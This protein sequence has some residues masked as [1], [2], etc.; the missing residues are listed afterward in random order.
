MAGLSTASNGTDN[1]PN[2]WKGAG[3][4]EFDLRSDTMTKP[5]MAMLEAISQSSLL[6]DVFG[7]DP[8]TN[9]LQAYVAQRTNHE[10]SLL[11]MSG[12]MGNQV[13][14]RTHLVQPP[15]SVLCD[16]RSHII[17]YEAGGVSSLTGATVQTIDP[18]NGSY[19]TLEDIQKY[20]VLDDDIHH[21]PTKLISLENTL[22]GGVLPLAEA[23]KITEWA[24]A[25][26]IKVHLDGAR[27]WEAVVS[28]AGS[29]P[30]YAG[31]FDSVSLC[32][33][34]GLGAPIGSII[35]GS[36][37]FIK[38][39]RW[40]RKAIGGGVRQAGVIAAAA[41]VAVDETFGPDPHGQGGKL[42]ETHAK[43]KKV[44]EMWQNLGGKLSQPVET[45]MVWLNLEAAGL[46]PNDLAEIGKERNLKLLGN[47]I[48]IHYQ[49]SEEAIARLGEVFG[50]AMS[51]NYQRS[52]DQSKPYGSR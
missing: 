39:A 29:L 21:C 12:T 23:R 17:C 14:I 24:H 37:E 3:A 11:V 6:D 45:N 43:A 48:V 26:G 42:R 13:A 44:A 10:D 1:K 9:D 40:F 8:V 41:R 19:L 49:V 33:S 50:L 38:K 35:V 25:N 20:A 22:D 51:G 46:G 30:E 7:E 36:S 27:L 5:T 16:R 15:Y 34:K 52:T 4:A 32:F 47:R 31:L 18:K 28:G 2:T